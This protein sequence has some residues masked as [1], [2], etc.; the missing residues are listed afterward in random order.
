M[1]E[2]IENGDFENGDLT[3]WLS[4]YTPVVGTGY[5]HLG[6]YGC[7]CQGHSFG[8]GYGDKI[9]QNHLIVPYGAMTLTFWFNM[10]STLTGTDNLQILNV[11]N[12]IAG[13][14]RLFEATIMA[15]NI[16]RVSN[17]IGGAYNFNIS[18]IPNWTYVRIVYTDNLTPI[19]VTVDADTQSIAPS[20]NLGPIYQTVLGALYTGGQPYKPVKEIWIDDVSLSYTVAPVTHIPTVDTLSATNVLIN[21][22]DLH[23]D[24]TD[25][26]N[27]DYCDERGFEWGIVEGVYTDSWTENEEEYGLGEFSHTISILNNTKYYFRAKAHNATGW[28]YGEVLNFTTV[29]A[30][31]M[32]RVESVLV[33]NVYLKGVQSAHWKDSDPW[34]RIPIPAGDMLHHHL[35]PNNIDGVITCYDIA[36]IWE[37]FYDSNIIIES[38]GEKTVFSPVGTE[39]VITLKDINNNPVSFNFSNVR[40]TTIDLSIAEQ[41]SGGEGLWTIRFTAKGV[42][43]Q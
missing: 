1:V 2:A 32:A 10:R 26:G 36:S 19:V 13:G 3:G 39:F 15:N 18:P 6:N 38:T 27:E 21:S 23:G 8:V 20:Y 9:Y 42:V 14:E 33:K 31:M 11:L 28:G 25:L 30:G 22:A 37:A 41:E 43:R 7:Q 17:G 12:S 24:I 40:I 29:I 35:M 4:S 5:K 16:L 34:V